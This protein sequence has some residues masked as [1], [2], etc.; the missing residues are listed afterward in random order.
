MQQSFSICLFFQ[1]AAA[2]FFFYM[3]CFCKFF[4]S[5][6]TVIHFKTAFSCIE[7]GL[8]GGMLVANPIPEEYSMDPATIHG[9]IEQAL[10]E[11]KAS[12]IQHGVLRQSFLTL[13]YNGN[14]PLLLLFF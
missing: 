6:Q 4:R 8:K 10:S 11:C 9:A 13:A 7:L 2:S 5:V 14:T 1:S 3:E 12:G